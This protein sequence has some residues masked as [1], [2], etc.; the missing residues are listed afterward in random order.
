[1]V[2]SG[3]AAEPEWPHEAGEDARRHRAVHQ[4]RQEPDRHER[5]HRAGPP[6]LGFGRILVQK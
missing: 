3:N 6:G 5:W 1:M 4:L 2:Q